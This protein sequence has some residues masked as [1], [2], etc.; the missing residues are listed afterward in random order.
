MGW[1][2][3]RWRRIGESAVSHNLPDNDDRWVLTPVPVVGDFKWVV[4][5]SKA[6]KNKYFPLNVTV[7][8]LC[9]TIHC[10][11][12]NQNQNTSLIP[13]GTLCNIYEWYICSPSVN[14]SSA[15]FGC[16][17]RNGVFVCA[18]TASLRKSRSPSACY[19]ETCTVIESII[20][21]ASSTRESVLLASLNIFF[22]RR[23]ITRHI[24]HRVR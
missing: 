8:E 14:S 20:E 6:F 21:W 24:R 9:S 4:E 17:T 10:F 12:L 23:C 2:N 18:T 22:T 19:L 3:T 1:F 16:F 7:C 11:H 5:E 13:E 15:C